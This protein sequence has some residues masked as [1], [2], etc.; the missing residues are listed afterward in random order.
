MRRNRILR[1]QL[2]IYNLKTKLDQLAKAA[3]SLG[4]VLTESLPA[5][6]IVSNHIDF[7][8]SADCATIVSPAWIRT[9]CNLRLTSPSMPD[10]AFY[11]ADPAKF[12][13]GLV[14]AVS[15]EIAEYDQAA[16]L[17]SVAAYGG[18]YR[19]S[20]TP[21]TTHFI[22]V[23]ATTETYS[24]ALIASKMPQN[25]DMFDP[26]INENDRNNTGGGNGLIITLPHFIDDCIKLKRHI[27]ARMYTF[28]D[29]AILRANE[30]YGP[31][32]KNN[33]SD[34]FVGVEEDGIEKSANFLANQKIFIDLACMVELGI[35]TALE[36]AGATVIDKFDAQ[37]CTLAILKRREGKIYV[38]CEQPINKIPV[39]TPAYLSHILTARTLTSPK[40]AL[41]HYPPPRAPIFSGLTIC[42]TNYVGAARVAIE[43]LVTTLG[44]TYT[45]QM[46]SANTHVVCARPWGSEK[47]ARASQWDVPVVNHLWVEACWREERV[48][49][50]C[51]DEFRWWSLWIGR[52]DIVGM[53]AVDV[54]KVG[55]SVRKAAAEVEVV[56]GIE[57]ARISK[58]VSE[59]VNGSG[60]FRAKL[61]VSSSFWQDNDDDAEDNIVHTPVSWKQKTARKNLITDKEEDKDGDEDLR[62]QS[63]IMPARSTFA[64]AVVARSTQI[65]VKPQLDFSDADD[66]AGSP[67]PSRRLKL[68]DKTVTTYKKV[69][70]EK[71]VKSAGNGGGDS[72]SPVSPEQSTNAPSPKK[73][74]SQSSNPP[75]TTKKSQASKTQPKEKEHLVIAIDADSSDDSTERERVT[76]R[77]VSRTVSGIKRTRKSSIP[78]G[79]GALSLPSSEAGGPLKRIKTT[80]QAAVIKIVSTGGAKIEKISWKD[81]LNMG[82]KEV[83]DV[84]N[85][86]HLIAD[87][88]VR[89]E[90]FIM[91]I[92]MGKQIVTSDWILKSTKA[93]RWIDEKNFRPPDEL[94]EYGMYSIDIAL[95]LAR[96]HK[97]LTGYVVY[98]TPHVIPS[99]ETLKRLVECAGGRMVKPLSLR[100]LTSVDVR[101]FTHAADKSVSSS[102]PRSRDVHNDSGVMSAAT[103]AIVD[104]SK[105]LV[106]SCE[107]DSTYTEKLRK[108]QSLTVYNVEVIVGSL[109][110]QVLNLNDEILLLQ[111]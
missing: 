18:Q 75:T 73:T 2:T 46:T 53:V 92:T 97:L 34:I 29:P 1:R 93:G 9:A 27:P 13:S 106:V 68:P 62:R 42:A 89:T 26:L 31:F 23:S 30:E 79:P 36:T 63:A 77:Q 103:P 59:I 72:S 78:I 19:L 95:S 15:D 49:G 17:G 39:A 101:L 91:A 80:D 45:R 12:F 41:L 98:A 51:R 57:N 107:E 52:K 56:S 25:F 64:A 35:I 38:E 54:G 71:F 8:G 82:A 14:V 100:K 33:V 69:S 74:K 47:C 65:S 111:D 83:S 40:N 16:I 44:G 58:S 81:A 109:M 76:A 55:E 87:K 84:P 96:K 88:I 104:I 66:A 5:S 24:E 32:G 67:L 105:V 7:P 50:V 4:F 108:F 85:C 86:T 48:V 20:L 110:N 70:P 43:A 37:I 11:S 99:W 21:D 102:P 60:D 10:P 22:A 90:K 28:P 61:T 94:N 3:E 6:I